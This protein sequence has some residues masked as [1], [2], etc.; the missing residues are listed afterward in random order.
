MTASEWTWYGWLCR[1]AL[2][3]NPRHHHT[4]PATDVAL[5]GLLE[6]AA[7]H[8]GRW[9]VI[10]APGGGAFGQCVAVGNGLL[11]VEVSDPVSKTIWPLGAVPAAA[12]PVVVRLRG[13]GRRRFA[14]LWFPPRALHA[15]VDAV[16]A[17]GRHLDGRPLPRQ[18]DACPVEVR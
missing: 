5:W 1:H 4:L 13:A 15:P 10:E 14:P 18:F 3:R 6:R 11:G 8:R 9:V 2:R 7:R 12:R 16:A 17:I